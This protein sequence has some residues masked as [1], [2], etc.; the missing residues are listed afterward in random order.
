MAKNLRISVPEPCH[1]NW[2]QMTPADKGR[3]CKSCDKVVVD[4]SRMTDAQV[5]AHFKSYQ[6][7]TCGRF[8]A[9]QLD[10]PMPLSV[11]QRLFRP[12]KYIAASLLAIEVFSQKAQA[13]D[14]IDTVSLQTDTAVATSV[15]DSLVAVDSCAIAEVDSC[16]EDSLGYSFEWK[17]DTVK[18][19]LPSDFIIVDDLVFSGF[20]TVIMGNCTGPSLIDKEM[21]LQKPSIWFHITD[22][23]NQNVWSISKWRA[24][25][26]AELYEAIKTENTPT[27][28]IPTRHFSFAALVRRLKIKKG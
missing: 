23:L 6:G 20:T 19:S 14:V 21:E 2:Q 3:H 26:N 7:K 13:R 27:K 24:I 11:G 15:A 10:R 9:E 25:R 18:Y 16:V 22:Y 8:R 12:I 4:F 1:E 17:T 5:V 28:K